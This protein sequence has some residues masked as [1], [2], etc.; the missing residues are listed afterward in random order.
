MAAW[1]FHPQAQQ[2]EQFHGRQTMSTPAGRS[3]QATAGRSHPPFQRG[4]RL[5]RQDGIL[6]LGPDDNPLAYY[7]AAVREL[8][9]EAAI[10]LAYD[11]RDRLYARA[12]DAADQR[13]APIGTCFHRENGHR[14]CGRERKGEARPRSASLLCHW[15]TPEARKIR[16]DTRF[17]LP[18]PHP[19]RRPSR[20][21][22]RQR[23]ASGFRPFRHLRKI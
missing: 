9:E 23:T 16:F 11:D 2:H 7:I 17:F 4:S 8:F 15:I 14:G 19:G 10:L 18:R 1:R 5:K 3:R 13:F 21:G 6:S 12:D 22:R 20:T